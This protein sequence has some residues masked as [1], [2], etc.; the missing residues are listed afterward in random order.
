MPRTPRRP[1][2]QP[3]SGS[4][5]IEAALALTLLTTVL[6]GAVEFG[7]AFVKLRG[8][9]TAVDRGAEF[10]ARALEESGEREVGAE[11]ETAIRNMALYGNPGGSDGPA[12]AGLRAE[13]VAVS[14][15]NDGA[16]PARVVVSVTG[17]R[18][19]A[20]GLNRM[21]D[22]R[23]RSVVTLG[24]SRSAPSASSATR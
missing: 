6:L 23:P 5:L 17:Y 9:Q 10:A 7:N 3:Q 24:G 16:W 22:G 4:A 14:V 18:F 2:L 1:K 19:A 12:I 20:P 15:E 11:L 13:Q 21:L 8:L